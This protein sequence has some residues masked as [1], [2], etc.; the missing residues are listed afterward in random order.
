MKKQ[1]ILLETTEAKGVGTVVW[2]TSEVVVQKDTEGRIIYVVLC[3][4]ATQEHAF[5]VTCKF[6]HLFLTISQE[7]KC[8]Y[9]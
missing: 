8:I 5:A 2:A 1:W 6:Y 3:N 4:F 7:A 9:C